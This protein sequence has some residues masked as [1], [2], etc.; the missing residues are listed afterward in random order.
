MNIASQKL[1]NN[2]EL[3]KFSSFTF[4]NKHDQLQFLLDHSILIMVDWKGEEEDL[5][6]G[7][8]LRQRAL[9]FK[10]TIALDIE[11]AYK[12]MHDQVAKGKMQTGDTVPFILNALQK[13][14][15]PAGLAI[16]LLDTGNDN[17]HIGVVKQEDLKSITDV[18][19]NF[20][21]YIAYGSK[22]GEVLY[23][24]ICSCGSMNVWQIK[25]GELLTDDYCQDCGKEIFDKE[26]KSD[27]TVVKDYI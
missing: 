21:P 19:N 17:Y 25:R 13:Q 23:T 3:E 22:T 26:G 12:K 4:K 1:M 20:Y 16:V 2:E 10:P 5:E 14:L 6:I 18:S 7:K 15:K 8:F 9:L 11:T 24:V 27:M